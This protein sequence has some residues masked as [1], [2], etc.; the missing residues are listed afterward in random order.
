MSIPEMARHFLDVTGHDGRILHLRPIRVDFALGKSSHHRVDDVIS[1]RRVVVKGDAYEGVVGD[2]VM[3]PVIERLPQLAA[4]IHRMWQSLRVNV[5][6]RTND[7]HR[8]AKIRRRERAL[9]RIPD[10]LHFLGLMGGCH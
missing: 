6:Y 2:G 8:A 5:H 4:L 7:V 3:A 1:V 10:V 9:F